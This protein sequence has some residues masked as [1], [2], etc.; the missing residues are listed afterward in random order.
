MTL[1]SLAL[2]LGGLIVADL[3]RA[4]YFKKKFELIPNFEEDRRSGRLDEKYALY[5]GLIEM[6]GGIICVICGAVGLVIMTS[7]YSIISLLVC[8]AV[9]TVAL[10]IN[11]RTSS[12]RVRLERITVKGKKKKR[13][14]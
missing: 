14:R 6:V 8:V 5:F 1:L 13:R 12:T 9:I 10:L 7:K 2:I 4:V 11:L 3:G